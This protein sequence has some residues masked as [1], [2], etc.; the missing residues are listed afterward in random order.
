MPLAV[1]GGSEGALGASVRRGAQIV[2][3]VGADALAESAAG[4]GA[5]ETQEGWG[6]SGE[7]GSG[8]RCRRDGAALRASIGGGSQ[9]IAA[10]RA[11]AFEPAMTTTGGAGA[12][13]H[14]GHR[15]KKGGQPHRQYDPPEGQRAVGR[16][17]HVAGE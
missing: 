15:G 12:E 11:P 14:R 9:I 16:A 10:A 2:A 3:A 7:G 13:D 17:A 6:D 8:L 1:R 5:S 4:S